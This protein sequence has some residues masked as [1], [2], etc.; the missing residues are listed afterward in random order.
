MNKFGWFMT[1]FY[2]LGM[3]IAV[4]LSYHDLGSV[5]QRAGIFVLAILGIGMSI[6]FLKDANPDKNEVKK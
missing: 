1:G 5:N 2:F 3:I 6:I 4:I